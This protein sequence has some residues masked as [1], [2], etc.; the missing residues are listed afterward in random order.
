MA[1]HF[2]DSPSALARARTDVDDYITVLTHGSSYTTYDGSF[3]GDI[4]DAAQQSSSGMLPAP[5]LP[6]VPRSGLN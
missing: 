5:A 3:G 2:G 1:E 6:R 4:R